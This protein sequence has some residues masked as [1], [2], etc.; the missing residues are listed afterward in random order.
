MKRSY[1]NKIFN[2]VN[3]MLMAVLLVIFVWPLWFVVIASF[4]DPNLV[5][6][7]EVLMFP[8][9]ITLGGYER[10][11]EY[12]Q[13]WVG[14]ANSTYY[15]IIGTLCSMVLSICL[16]YPMSDKTFTPRKVLMIIFMVSMYFGGGLIPTYLLLR[17]LHI[18]NTRWAM[19]IPGVISVYNSLIIRS[20]FMNSIPGEL[21]EAATLDGAN[22]AHYLIKV[23]L[24]LSKSVF[25]VVGL[26]YAVGYWNNY[27]KA[28]YYIYDDALMPLQMVLRELLM[29]TKLLAD[30]NMDPEL[31]AEAL[32]QA[33]MMKYCVIIAAAVPM[34]CIYPFVQKHFV[35]GVMVG[36][37]KG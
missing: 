34:L 10:M 21:K 31:M 14:Y 33:Q 3:V 16:A 5:N 9:G 36:A 24:P 12:K 27:T 6:S 32:E 22:A 13:I 20:Y 8:K 18:V 2:V 28:L 11:L 26:Y 17:S 37:V 23:V 7:G 4:S 15:T 19:I 1:S 25:A 29:S 30:L 35:K